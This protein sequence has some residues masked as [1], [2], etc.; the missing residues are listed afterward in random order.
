MEEMK[1]YIFFEVSK[2]KLNC[3]YRNFMQGLKTVLNSLP[4]S[5]N[6]SSSLL[7]CPMHA[8]SG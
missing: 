6:V 3:R 1:E 8:C 7:A 4:V 5:T 2:Y